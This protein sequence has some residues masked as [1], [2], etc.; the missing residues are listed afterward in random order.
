MR[1][2]DDGGLALMRDG[3]TAC[4]RVFGSSPGP[5]LE[6]RPETDLNAL[7]A[8]FGRE[9]ALHLCAR[10]DLTQ[11]TTLETSKVD[12]VNSLGH[13]ERRLFRAILMEIL[14]RCMFLARWN[15]KRPP[16][17]RGAAMGH[18]RQAGGGCDFGPLG[19]ASDAGAIGL[20]WGSHPGPSSCDL[21]PPPHPGHRWRRPNA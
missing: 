21:D 15:S 9:H 1:S 8:L 7:R 2:R 14:E 19:G 6:G 20:R 4:K 12:A 10:Q 5:T 3:S 11:R 18:S 13:I 17:R 16:Y